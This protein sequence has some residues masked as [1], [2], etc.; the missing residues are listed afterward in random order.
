[1]AFF[2]NFLEYAADEI[3][4]VAVLDVFGHNLSTVCILTP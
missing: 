4:I 3:D 2:V 1:M